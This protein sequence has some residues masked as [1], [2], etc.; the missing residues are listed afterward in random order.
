MTAQLIY[1]HLFKK[2]FWTL[3]GYLAYNIIYPSNYFKI[4]SPFIPELKLSTV[5]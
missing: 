2:N 4:A 1:Q 3:W 5:V